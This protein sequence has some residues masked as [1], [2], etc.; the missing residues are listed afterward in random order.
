MLSPTQADYLIQHFIVSRLK[1]RYG[2]HCLNIV[3]EEDLT[4]K[5]CPQFKERVV[6]K[7]QEIKVSETVAAFPKVVE[8]EGLY[9]AKELCIWIDPLDCTQG[10]I[11]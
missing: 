7:V 2:E 11:N 6:K 8:F 3:A 4:Y 9:E 1:D 10:F 5:T